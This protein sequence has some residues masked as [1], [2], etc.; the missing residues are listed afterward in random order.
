[1][2]RRWMSVE[3]DTYDG[4]EEEKSYGDVCIHHV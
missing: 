3:D 2:I 1:M 4:P